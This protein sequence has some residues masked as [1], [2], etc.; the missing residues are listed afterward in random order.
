MSNSQGGK[1]NVYQYKFIKIDLEG[2]I[3]SKPEEDYKEIINEQARE[4]WK[5]LQIFAPNTYGFGTVTYMEL[6]FE[7]RIPE[8]H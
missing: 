7:R 6:I 8:Y 1:L 5:L 4:G 3:Q 2:F